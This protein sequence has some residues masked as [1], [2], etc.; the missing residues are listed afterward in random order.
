MDPNEKHE[1]TRNH[2]N[3]SRSHDSFTVLILYFHSF[4]QVKIIIL[5]LYRTSGLVL[6][7]MMCC[8]SNLYTH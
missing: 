7:N 4:V 3:S 5:S 8:E 6:L 1:N 2:K